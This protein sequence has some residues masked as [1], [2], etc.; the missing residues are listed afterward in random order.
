M[1]KSREY[2][3][4]A[5]VMSILQLTITSCLALSTE[6][7]EKKNRKFA[8]KLASW[9]PLIENQVLAIF[10]APLSNLEI[11]DL[12]RLVMRPVLDDVLQQALEDG[13]ITLE[14]QQLLDIINK[15]LN[16]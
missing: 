9:T 14:E 11:K 5:E 1:G 4:A 3:S 15:N 12:L 10:E 13:V 8:E 16:F 6:F 2:R 7:L